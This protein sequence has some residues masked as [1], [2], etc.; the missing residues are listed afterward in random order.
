MAYITILELRNYLG[1][2][3]TDDDDLMTSFVSEA[4]TFIEQYTGRVFEASADTTRKFNVGVDTD[5]DLLFFDEEICAITTVTNNADGTTETLTANTDYIT[6]PRNET[7]YT[8][9][10]I[11]SGSSKYWRYTTNSENG[12]T[13]AG[14]WAFSTTAPS[15][16]KIACKMLAGYYYRQKDSQVFDV[17]AIPDA[18]V[19]TIPKGVPA[20]VHRILNNRKRTVYI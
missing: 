17:T 14:K 8:A 6:I 7:P 15:D 11:M 4:Q 20:S 5:G 9:I 16:I 19:I 3:G 2:T 13:V 10:K 12:I 1:I 18:G